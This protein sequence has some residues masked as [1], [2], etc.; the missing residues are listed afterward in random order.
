[1]TSSPALPS[2]RRLALVIDD[3]LTLLS[4]ISG[5]LEDE[6]YQVMGATDGQQGLA[7]FERAAAD[8]VVTD[9][10]MPERE[11]V[12]TIMAIKALKP[13]TPILAISG[14][15]RI[16]ADEFLKLAKGLGA[17]AALAKPFRRADLLAAVQALTSSDAEITR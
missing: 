5:W 7:K 10:I 1:M 14:G 16:G 17:D 13:A 15:G 11:G 9:L 3:D 2:K 6:G 12:E 8:I 4:A